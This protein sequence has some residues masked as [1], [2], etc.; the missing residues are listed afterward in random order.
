[1]RIPNRFG[2]FAFAL[3]LALPVAG[4][5]AQNPAEFTALQ[6]LSPVTALGNT[7]AG[8]AALAANHATTGAIQKG[9]A[10]Q[11]LLLPFPAQQQLA[12]RDAFITRGNLDQLADGLG[13]K[14]DAAY[15]AVAT[16]S[17][18]D[19]GMTSRFT[20][21]SPAVAKL[22][23]YTLAT[24]G[25]DAD[26]GKYF[27]ANATRNGTKPVSDAAKAILAGLHGVTDP[28]GV[29]YGLPAGSPGADKFGNSRPFQ[30]V[31]NLLIY[32]GANHFGV[33]ADNVMYL[34]GPMQNLVDSP[35]YPSGHTTYGYSG[36]LLLAV[37]VPER[38]EQMVVR[39][40]EY[41]NNRI[42]IGAHYVMDVLGGR[43]LALHDLAHLLAN[44]PGYVGVERKGETVADF[45]KLLAEARADMTRA[46]EAGCGATV[47]VCAGQDEGRFADAARN[48]KFYAA[49]QTYAMPV[50]FPKVAAA[51]EDVAK[52]APE[53]GYLLT[54]AFPR[55]SLA[56]ADAIL[57]ETEG[58]GGGFLDNGSAFGVYSRLDLARAARRAAAMP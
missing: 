54:V 2:A 1:M 17:S 28:F 48:A 47:V 53:A 45:P 3:V 27:F 42:I 55:L 31:P 39:G 35:S 14:L 6:G 43:T 15:Q 37:L 36:S 38:Y 21:V 44:A 40:A 26:A 24:S 7:P 30:T 29:A 22:I 16:Y 4:A 33:P 49:T 10:R 32:E 11:P 46:L 41:G 5:R 58:P 9:T 12:L 56:Q 8:K 51:P 52:L 25:A 13:S 57:T 19:G 50:V 34:R 20:N 18:P 23:T